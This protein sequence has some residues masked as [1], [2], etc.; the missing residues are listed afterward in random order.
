[1]GTDQKHVGRAEVV[2]AIRFKVT[3]AYIMIPLSDISFAHRT[4]MIHL[5]VR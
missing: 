5:L 2:S 1:M 3:K 4:R